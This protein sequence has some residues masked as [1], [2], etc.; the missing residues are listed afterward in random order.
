MADKLLLQIGDRVRKLRKKQGW[1]QVEMAQKTGLDRS[2][3]ADVER[4]RRNV[5]IQESL[6]NSQGLWEEPLP[7]PLGNLKASPP[8]LAADTAIKPSNFHPEYPLL[9][10]I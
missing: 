9:R 6:H 4:G 5:S 7:V 10:R 3:L 1:T 2:F 8:I